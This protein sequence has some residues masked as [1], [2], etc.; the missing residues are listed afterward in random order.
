MLC[1]QAFPPRSQWCFFQLT[2]RF[3][4]ARSGMLPTLQGMGLVKPGV[5]HVAGSSAGSLVAAAVSAGVP[6]Q[7]VTLM[8]LQFGDHHVYCLLGQHSCKPNTLAQGLT[9]TISIRRCWQGYKT[10]QPTAEKKV[11]SDNCLLCWG[12]NWNVYCQTTPMSAAQE[13]H[14]SPSRVYFPLSRKR[15]VCHA[16]LSG[17]ELVCC[18]QTHGMPFL[19]QGLT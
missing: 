2:P 19:F 15:L 10:V 3:L 8:M 5:T 18:L 11:F 1:G 14:I 6:A 9:H 16:C 12:V 7:E 17:L 13:P 4:N